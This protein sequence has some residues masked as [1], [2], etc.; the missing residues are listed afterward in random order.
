MTS[1]F[2]TELTTDLS[3]IEMLT[4]QSLRWFLPGLAN[5]ILTLYLTKND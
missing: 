1:R 5:V 3:H 4:T 2:C